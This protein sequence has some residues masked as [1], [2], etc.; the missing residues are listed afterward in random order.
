MIKGGDYPSPQAHVGYRVQFWDP[1]HR[2]A[3]DK[4][5]QVQGRAAWTGLSQRGMVGGPGDRHKVKHERFS[6]GTREKHFPL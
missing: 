3:L 6:L 1:Q 4:A 2:E 5:E